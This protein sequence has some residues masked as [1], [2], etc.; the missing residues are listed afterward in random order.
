MQTFIYNT[1]KNLIE[2]GPN[3]IQL[4]KRLKKNKMS[5]VRKQEWKQ[6]FHQYNYN[7][8]F[9]ICIDFKSQHI[10]FLNNFSNLFF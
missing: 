3:L 7:Q 4:P 10:V 2:I 9:H 6:V 1:Q 5:K 8:I